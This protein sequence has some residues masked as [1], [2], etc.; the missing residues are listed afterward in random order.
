LESVIDYVLGDVVEL[1]VRDIMDNMSKQDIFDS[2]RLAYITLLAT[3]PLRVDRIIAVYSAEADSACG[4]AVLDKKGDVLDHTEISVDDDPGPAVK[5]MVD[6]HQPNAIVLPKSDRDQGRIQK[7]EEAALPLTAYRLDIIAV[8]EARKKLS[9]GEMASSAVVLGRRLL[10]PGR[11]WG[12]VDPLLLNLEEIGCRVDHE[13][14]RRILFE[15]KLISSW[16]RRQK[17]VPK[18][19]TGSRR[20]AAIRSSGKKLNP[21]LKSIRDLKPGMTVE[22]IITNL[23]RFGAFVNIGLPVEGMIHVSQLSI[24]FVEDPSHVVKIGQQLE[25]RVLEV[26]PEKERIALSLKPTHEQ[27]A[28]EKDTASSNARPQVTRREPPKTRTA[29]LADLDALFKK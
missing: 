20:K 15:A 19:P 18:Q 14:L 4:V 3:K 22:G 21:S 25:V 12:R 6:C 1:V 17:K 11:E 7:I 24:E 2:V 27:Q 10:K 16:N 23:T 26:V 13:Q 28:Q 29:A 5:N 8:E 9:F